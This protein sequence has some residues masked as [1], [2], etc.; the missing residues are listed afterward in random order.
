MDKQ[1]SVQRFL[2]LIRRSHRGKFKI[3]IGMSAGV[4]K[5][6][7]MLQEA[8]QLLEAGV[9]VRIGYIETHGRPDTEALLEGLPVVPLR[10]LF[11]KGKELEEMDTQ[12][13]INLHPEIVIVDELAHT[14]IEGSEN[15]KRWQDV[16]QILDA[17]ISVIS[18]VN[19]QHIE[20]LNEV[21][22]EIT[23]IEI[24]ERVPDS[25]LA[26]ADEVVNIDLTA[27]ELIERLKA[28]KI[29][30]PDKI[31]AALGNFFTQ[32]NLLQLRELALKEVPGAA[33]T[34]I[35]LELEKGIYVYQIELYQ[36]GYEYDLVLNAKDGARISLKSEKDD[37]D[38]NGGWVH[39]TGR[40]PVTTEQ[41]QAKA[42]EKPTQQN[43]ASSYIGVA[44]AK[45]IVLQ[46]VPGATITK[47]ELERDDGRV[48]YEGEAQ[49]GKVEYEF[50]IDAYTGAILSWEEEQSHHSGS[51]TQPAGKVIGIKQVKAILEKKMPGAIIVD[52]DM[53]TVNGRLLYEGE[54]RKSGTEYDFEIDATTGTILKWEAEPA[55]RD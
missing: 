52:L 37:W 2:E 15:P 50:D 53:D 34:D 22:E 31:A 9:D 36:G 25:V 26:M 6:Y 16:M 10:K 21:V 5:T 24:R 48:A 30:R 7:R 20:G 43:G 3:Y 44:K 42:Q 47:I 27:D 13:I 55:D 28:G 8:H 19:I 1:D 45:E 23:G 17:G 39:H 18:A 54:V 46:K 14:N 38:E 33:V 35:D 32:D 49:K 11:Y 4:G 41:T 40:N 12:A 51:G 29:Y